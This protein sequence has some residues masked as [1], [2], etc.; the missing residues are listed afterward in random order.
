MVSFSLS[1]SVRACAKVSI[2]YKILMSQDILNKN[3]SYF[4]TKHKYH[5][6]KIECEG[7]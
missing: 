1:L 3:K 5:N 7:V 2:D 4:I 6:G